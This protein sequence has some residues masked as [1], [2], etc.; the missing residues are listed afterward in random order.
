MVEIGATVI[1]VYM[2]GHWVLIIVRPA[3][4]TVYYMNSLPNH[5][6]DENMRNIV[7][8]ISRILIRILFVPQT[9]LA[10][11]KIWT[12]HREPLE[13]T[14]NASRNVEEDEQCGF[15]FVSEEVGMDDN[16]LG[17]IGFDPYEFANVIGDGDQ[18]LYPGSSKYTILS[19]LVKLYNLKAKHGMSD[20]CFTKLLILQGDLLP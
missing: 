9:D 10:Y 12:W 2:R 8:T 16:D 4:E 17:D 5:S 1:A 14:T 15:S 3:K 13:L 11:Y 6:V 19:A 7:N 20:V 18:P